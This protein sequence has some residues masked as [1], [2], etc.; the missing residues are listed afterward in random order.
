[1]LPTSV[2]GRVPDEASATAPDR[3]PNWVPELD[4]AG[5]TADVIHEVDS[6]LA[7]LIAQEAGGT[8][9]VEVVFDAPT[10]E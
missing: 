7:A 4:P 5:H 9:G 10:K 8:K 2:H 1:V 6:A 3:A